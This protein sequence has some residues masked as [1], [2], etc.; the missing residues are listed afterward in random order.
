MISSLTGLLAK[1]RSDEDRRFGARIPDGQRVYAVGDIHGRAD[2]LAELL[3]QLK[4]D[5]EGYVGQITFIGLGDYIDRGRE[6]MQAVELLCTALPAN[7]TKVFL[8]GNHEQAMLD[9]LEDPRRGEWLA[10]GGLEALASYDIQPFGA[11]GVRETDALAAELEHALKE[12][13]HNDFYNSTVLSYVCGGYAFV[14]AGVRPR[15]S[16]DKQLPSDLLFIRD[17]FFGR[18]HGLPYRI[19]FGHTILPDILLADDRIGLD[20]G[21]FQ[22]GV[23]SAV[24]L[25]GDD[26]RVLQA[27]AA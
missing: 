3:E 15:V 16:L 19:V 24:A 2:L 18:P 23:L 27:I 25:E 22:S 21:A 11:R 10:W 7:W 1:R 20:T 9:F 13:K 8:R 26:V 5:A 17:D 4:A 14:H 6:S 12:T